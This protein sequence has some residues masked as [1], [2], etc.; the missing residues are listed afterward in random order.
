MSCLLAIQTLDEINS[1]F[2]LTPDIM[3]YRRHGYD[4]RSSSNSIRNSTFEHMLL[5][6]ILDALLAKKL[7]SLQHHGE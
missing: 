5:E 3:P 2:L 6:K 4:R 1:P 7:A